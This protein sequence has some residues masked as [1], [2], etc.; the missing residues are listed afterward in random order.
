[1]EDDEAQKTER[2]TS[3]QRQQARGKAVHKKIG[4]KNLRL[5]QADIL[6]SLSLLELRWS[7]RV[8]T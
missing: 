6:F 4:K 5:K 3:R 2:K 1:V 8:S 7:L